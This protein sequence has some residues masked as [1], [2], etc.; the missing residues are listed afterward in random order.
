MKLLIGVKFNWHENL[1]LSL[2]QGESNSAILRQRSRR[3]IKKKYY[4]VKLISLG[5]TEPQIQTSGMFTEWSLG[6]YTCLML[7]F[8]L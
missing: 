4:T 6:I 1:C 3:A 2:L 5:L 8:C 7:I